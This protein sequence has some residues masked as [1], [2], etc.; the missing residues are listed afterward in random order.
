MQ[1]LDVPVHALNTSSRAAE[2]GELPQMR[3]GKVTEWSLRQLG[4]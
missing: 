2:T 3:L 4:V 1:K